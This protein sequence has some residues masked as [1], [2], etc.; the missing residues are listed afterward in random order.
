VSRG[1]C[2][3]L[4]CRFERLAEASEA[5]TIRR[6]GRTDPGLALRVYAQAMRRGEDETSQLR[7]LIEGGDGQ[8][9]PTG[10][11][12][13]RDIL[14]A[15]GRLM[16]KHPD[17]QGVFSVPLLGIYSNQDLRGSLSRLTKKLAAVQA[18][19]GPRRQPVSRRHRPRRPGWV[20][21]AIVQV[22]TDRG[23]SMQVKDIHAAVEALVG[24]PV[25]P[26]SVE[27]GLA[28]NVAGSSARFVRV[29]RG[30]YILARPPYR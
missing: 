5:L 7:A 30:R 13:G 23:A 26:P 18:N 25:P 11:K 29:A 28:K 19:G 27:G 12:R 10:R 24:E 9:W 22:L 3:P 15:D 4:P 2:S 1:G 17:L 8:Q 14:G 16:H 6:N 21:E 20:L